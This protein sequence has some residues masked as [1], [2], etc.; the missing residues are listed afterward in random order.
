MD[1]ISESSQPPACRTLGPIRDLERHLPQD[2]WRK[3]FNAVYLKTDGDVVE[4][5]TNTAQDVDALVRVAGLKPSHHILDLCCG[6]GRH[7]IELARRGFEYVTGLDRSR[8]LVR[9]ARR[10]ASREGV[11]VTFRE[12]DARK[13]RLP[14]ASFDAV[15]LLGN[16]FGYFDREEDD[17]AVLRSVLRVL[18]PHGCLFLD[19]TDGD[20]MRA[21]YEPR[22]W[23]WLDQNHFVCRE[24]AL[25]QDGRRL[26]SREVVTHAERGVIADQFYAERLYSQ[27]EIL[28]LLKD[29]G[30]VD[31]E[32]VP[33]PTTHS[34]RGQDLGMMAERI[35]LFGRKPSAPAVTAKKGPLFP[36]VT[37]L[38]G[39]PN[40]PDIVKLQGQ[41]NADDMATVE[42]MKDALATL[43]DFTF[44][45]WDG[46]PELAER[47]RT[48]PPKFVMN[49]CDEGF[50]NDAFMELHVPA[51][52]EMQRIPYSGAGPASLG[53]CYNK[54]LV[55]AAARDL[56]VPV[57]LESYF[58]P[59]DQAAT[60]PS[61]FPALLKPNFGDS[62]QGITKD[63]V[64]GTQSELL[65]YLEHLRTSF[66]RRPI[67]I[68]EFL[69]GPEYSVG[70][71][72]NPGLDVTVLPILE[73]DYSG[74]EPGLPPILGYESKWMPDSPYW[75]QIRYREA[76]LNGDTSRN[77]ADHALRLF[78]YL[79]CRDYARIDFRTDSKGVIKLLEV[80]PNPGWCWD[81]KMNIM[82]GLAG[83]SYADLLRMV[84]ESAQERYARSA[85]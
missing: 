57:P 25:A 70:I 18:R 30:F 44:S 68:Q 51:L 19:L 74:L 2:W 71:V 43:E 65:E 63:A 81:G 3:L 29:A 76:R 31:V 69:N 45:Y 9:L 62:S 84:L 66:P 24:R 4:N 46:H 22:S 14:A 79:E 5:Q 42:R 12:G 21:H 67:L 50:M 53:W 64:V 75:D 20:W 36:S 59:D 16:S 60:L 39:D 72:G 40:L 15:T 38:L 13:F 83:M 34:D 11:R 33:S 56:E 7:S 1:T 73:V 27:E 54:A 82:A 35:I 61:I 10:R 17:L 37:V 77:L 80:N 8:Y 26:V 85:T 78:E 6:Q 55:R 23:E 32:L 41:F 52:L 47:L 48:E 28:S 58:S 49:L